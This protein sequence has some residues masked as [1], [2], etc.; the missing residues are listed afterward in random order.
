MQADIT[1]HDITYNWFYFKM[2]L[3]ITVNKKHVCNVT[4][5]KVENK[6]VISIV[7]MLVWCRQIAENIIERHFWTVKQ[8]NIISLSAVIAEKDIVLKINYTNYSFLCNRDVSKISSPFLN[9]FLNVR[10]GQ[11]DK[12]NNET[13]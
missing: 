9:E 10:S 6:V 13:W 7:I 2:T 3:L 8:F 1:F 5:I 11:F 4:F 12:K